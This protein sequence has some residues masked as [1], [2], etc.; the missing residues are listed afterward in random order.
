MQH[1]FSILLYNL[2][3]IIFA[4]TYITLNN[5]IM[6]HKNTRNKK[7]RLSSLV[8]AV[9]S[10]QKTFFSKIVPTPITIPDHDPHF[11][12]KSSQRVLGAVM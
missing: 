11:F 7:R 9:P 1:I 5:I 10:A 6:K 12:Q 4:R 3:S 2:S 8:K